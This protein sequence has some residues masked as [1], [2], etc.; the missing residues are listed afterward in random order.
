M[1]LIIDGFNIAFRSHYI[2]DVK[3]EL[4]TSDGL[5]TGIVYGFLKT[6]VKWKSKFPKHSIYIA[7]DTPGAKAERREI[8]AG[9]KANRDRDHD[10]LD[11][12]VV[13][14]SSAANKVLDGTTEATVN[15]FDLQILLLKYVLNYLGVRQVEA[16]K[17]EADDIIFNLV[18]K[19]LKEGSNI[20][21]SADRDLLQLVSWNTIMMTP[22]GVVYDKDKV[23]EEYS[24]RPDCFLAYRS[25]F[26]DK[27]DGIPGLFRFRKKIMARLVSDHD[28]DL[29]SIFGN[30]EDEKLTKKELEKL[31]EF[32]E[33]AYTNRS[34]MSFIDKKYS[35]RE[36]TK[37]SAKVRQFCDELEFKSIYSSLVDF[38]PTRGFV[39][40]GNE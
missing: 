40:F 1:N 39:R 9:Y 19:D 38:E 18:T 12:E 10:I 22:K 6:L 16:P 21:L 26:G 27:S 7:W 30:L 13:K 33:Q 23:L 17:T 25:L 24:V 14:N 3:Q 28:G 2:Y 29:E 34:V 11:I 32:E 20:I 36:G 4:S 31:E 37:D 35:I 5:P 8:Y 15:G